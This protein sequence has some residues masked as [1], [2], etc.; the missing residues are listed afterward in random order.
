[1]W[2]NSR[3]YQTS[4]T[5]KSSP[6]W[7]K[8]DSQF[9]F[10]VFCKLRGLTDTWTVE[11][12]VPI[13]LLPE[14]KEFSPLYWKVDFILYTDSLRIPIEAKGDWAFYGESYVNLRHHLHVFSANQPDLFHN[15]ILVTKA[16]KKISKHFSSTPIELVPL[17][18]F[19]LITRNYGIR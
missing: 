11:R 9:E 17:T 1:M 6:L 8:F 2:W 16:Q 12:Q 10:D 4:L 14:T 5:A 19:N 3:T 18:L 7:E 13:L 15:F